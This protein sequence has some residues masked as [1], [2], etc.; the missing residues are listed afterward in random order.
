MTETTTYV[1]IEN[2]PGYLPDDD[3]P[4]VTDDYAA[5]CEYV[6]ELTERLMDHI[7]EGGG[8]PAATFGEGHAYVTDMSREHDLGRVIEVITETA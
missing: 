2:T 5:A 8:E 1:V 7:S 6:R 3:D 4:F